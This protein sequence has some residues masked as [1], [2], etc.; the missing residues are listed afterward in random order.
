[1]PRPLV[2][3]AVFLLSLLFWL[4]WSFPAAPLLQRLDSPVVAD[5]PLHIEGVRGL[6][7]RGSLDWRWQDYRG[8]LDWRLGWKGMRPGLELQVRGNGA[9]LAGWVSGT[10]GSVLLRDLMVDVPVSLVADE[11]PD[12]SADGRVEGRAERLSWRPGEAPRVSGHLHYS[13]GHMR[14]PDGES[15]V[16]PLEGELYNEDDAG[17][18]AV[19]DPQGTLLMDGRLSADELEFRLYRAWPVLLGVSE[20]GDPDDVIFQVTERLAAQ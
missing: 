4:I 5:Q 18:L 16:P 13:G 20:G 2:L 7:R 3:A 9:E 8:R 6:A 1:M 19:H 12:H 15:D 14:W 11:I 10:P 17:W